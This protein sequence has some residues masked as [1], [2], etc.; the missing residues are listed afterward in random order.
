M[1]DFIMIF[2]IIMLFLSIISIIRTSKV[3]NDN[4]DK[5]FDAKYEMK[6]IEKLLDDGLI[7]KEQYAERG[8]LIKEINGLIYSYIR[9]KKY[10]DQ[11]DEEALQ[12][13]KA[14]YKDEEG[15]KLSM[16]NHK[17]VQN[18][19]KTYPE[20]IDKNIEELRKMEQE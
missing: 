8:K 14:L 7:T 20:L 6:K 16:E 18:M 4:R 17:I 1:L 13:A 15:I 5:L 19:I 3:I 12:I 10:C 9:A 2:T 11:T